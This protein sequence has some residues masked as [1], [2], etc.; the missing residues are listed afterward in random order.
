[1]NISLE[2]L[3]LKY[4]RSANLICTG[5]YLGLLI[6]TTQLLVTA[7]LTLPTQLDKRKRSPQDG[8]FASLFPYT[9]RKPTLPLSRLTG[10]SLLFCAVN[11]LNNWAFAFDISVPLHI[12]LRSFGSVTTLVLGWMVGKRYATLQVVGVAGLTV[13]VIMAAWADAGS[14]V[15]ANNTYNKAGNHPCSTRRTRSWRIQ[16]CITVPDTLFHR[17]QTYLSVLRQAAAHPPS[18]SAS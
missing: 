18:R 12:I 2:A 5:T 4:G 17:A 8:I 16:V 7:L 10:A 6:T 13:G 9:I 15:R 3:P 14:K 11:L 1:M